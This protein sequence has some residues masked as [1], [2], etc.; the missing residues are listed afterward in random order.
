MLKSAPFMSSAKVDEEFII[1]FSRVQNHEQHVQ[2]AQYGDVWQADGAN[3][4]PNDH[5][6]RSSYVSFHPVTTSLALDKDRT[7]SRH[8]YC[9]LATYPSYRTRLDGSD[10]HKVCTFTRCTSP[11]ESGYAL[12]RSWESVINFRD[13]VAA[14]ARG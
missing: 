5:H 6:L 8:G 14:S 1:A 11:C 4:R 10:A 9:A 13:F 3:P 12:F 2:G 7:F